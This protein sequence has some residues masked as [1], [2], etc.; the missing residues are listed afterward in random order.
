MNVV[1]YIQ[2]LLSPLRK[3]TRLI[4]FICVPKSLFECSSGRLV[5][6]N[7]LVEKVGR[8]VR[9]QNCAIP[10]SHRRYRRREADEWNIGR[11]QH[12]S[13]RTTIR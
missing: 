11:A 8:C 4:E 7:E 12:I 2:E 13:V 5:M 1:E 9:R 10:A 6:V 3:H